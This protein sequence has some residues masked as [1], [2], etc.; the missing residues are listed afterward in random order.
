MQSAS[1][2]Y[3]VFAAIQSGH[4]LQVVK[5]SFSSKVAG[6][7]WQRQSPLVLPATETSLI[8]SILLSFEISYI[9]AESS[10]EASV[11]LCPSEA[12]MHPVPPRP[13]R[14]SG[15]A[16]GLPSPC[17]SSIKLLL[18][19]NGCPDRTAVGEAD[20]VAGQAWRYQ[21]LKL[22]GL[23]EVAVFRARLCAGRLFTTCIVRWLKSLAAFKVSRRIA[24]TSTVASSDRSNAWAGL[25]CLG[26]HFL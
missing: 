25:A 11:I 5:Q 10:S 18:H 22:G 17:Q 9:K 4:E 3:L 12:W 15:S 24:S 23:A 6:Q 14:T 2:R 26:Q 21:V 7:D 13:A 19:P 8:C 20:C 1:R 16:F